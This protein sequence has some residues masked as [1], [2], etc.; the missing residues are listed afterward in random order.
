MV[1]NCPVITTETIVPFA[2]V[3]LRDT[4]VKVV[5]F[6]AGRGVPMGEA[7][8]DIVVEEY[9]I[10]IAATVV[11]FTPLLNTYKVIPVHAPDAPEKVEATISNF[12]ALTLK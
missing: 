2:T 1:P 7:I 6:P 5:S 8:T 4:D 10:R 12:S 3:G 9:V 11:F